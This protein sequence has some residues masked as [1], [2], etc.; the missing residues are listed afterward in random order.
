MS[1]PL[2][3]LIVTCCEK[4][5]AES[6]V[7]SASYEPVLTVKYPP[8]FAVPTAVMCTREFG[9]VVPDT[10]KVPPTVVPSPGNTLVM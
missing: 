6:A 1:P 5:P 10:V 3:V 2:T 9:N 4:C 8:M 7:T